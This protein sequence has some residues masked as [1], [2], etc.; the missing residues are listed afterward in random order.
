MEW[1][2]YHPDNPRIPVSMKPLAQQGDIERAYKRDE[3]TLSWLLDEFFPANPGSRFVSIHELAKWT[4]PDNSEVSAEQ[5]KALASD[6]D[7][8]FRE[9]PMEVPS[10]A[11]SGDT[12]F[13]LAESFGLFS[14]ALA[15]MGETAAL[16]K[17]VKLTH[18]YG[19]IEIPEDNMGVTVASFT[20]RDVMRAAAQIAPKMRSSEWKLVPDNAV[21][22]TFQV[23]NVSLNAGQFLR[24][25][26]QACLD[27]TPDKILKTN[28]ILMYSRAAF[29]Y[30]K[31]IPLSFLSSGW[32]FKPAVLAY[33]SASGTNV[34]GIPQPTPKTSPA[35]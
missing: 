20:V 13:S 18:P 23:G 9:M 34:A 25:M 7:A 17:Q 11:R 32:T 29:M 3:A 16:P 4:Q 15:G 24:A 6:L 19:P 28:A 31:N 8:R 5:I 30:P 1:L 33:Q 14:T 22:Y 21:P 12:Y 35:R 2:Y 10:F 27:P 26:A